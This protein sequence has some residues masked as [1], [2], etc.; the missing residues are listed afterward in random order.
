MP[1]FLKFSVYR[2]RV[3]GLFLCC[4]ILVTGSWLSVGAGTTAA[5]TLADR[6]SYLLR[7]DPAQLN[8][9]QISISIVKVSPG[10]ALP[11][12]GYHPNLP[13]MPGSNGKLLTTSAAFAKLGPKGVLHTYLY[14][15]GDDLVIVGGGDPALGDP[16]LCRQVGWT[17]TTAFDNWAAYLKKIG[18]THFHD[19]IVDDHIFNQHFFN[20]Q[21]P[22]GQ[23]LDWYEAQVCG[24]NFSDNCLNWLPTIQ[25]N[26]APGV[27]IFP[28]TPY[29]PVT[30]QARRGPV[31]SVWMYRQPD[32]N[33]FFCRGQI[34]YSDT[35]YPLQVTINNPALYTGAV[36]KQ[37]F[38]SHGIAIS[39]AVRSE[40]LTALAAQKGVRPILLAS[41]GTP[42]TDILKRAHIDS[43]NLM[44]ECLC[45]LLGH[46][47]TG[48]PGS[49]ANGTAA[50][51]AYL[52]TIGVNA[53]LT[54]MVDGSGL[55][56]HDRVATSAIT[57]IL[58]HVA[59]EPQGQVF[60]DTMA[61]PG[62]GTF[63]NRL[64]RSPARVF[65]RVKDG[66]VTGAS[67]LSGYLTLAQA[68]YAFAIFVNHYRGNVN[69]WEDQ[70]VNALYN[71]VR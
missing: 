25:P 62:Q 63:V 21:W 38:L 14:R 71:S 51:K 30:I 9:S 16:V 58:A 29:T 42:L 57:T 5:A 45:K 11:I 54:H 60:I 53:A 15:V 55:S 64:T 35:A 46:D 50:V 34:R 69:G 68:R 47:A 7:S 2:H 28:S 33:H 65:L 1:G 31:Q 67:T 19:V 56:H 39:G 49:W 48:Q 43:Y 66:H 4:L 18:Q 3:S 61:K 23:S 6:I 37:S 36:L 27:R 20:H 44:A 70:V 10:M 13:L 24:L 26:G 22:R 17:V 59:A 52:G 41:Y 8:G 40:G 12:Y 32:S